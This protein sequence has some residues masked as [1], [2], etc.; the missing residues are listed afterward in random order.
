MVVPPY[1]YILL[2]LSI[3]VTDSTDQ[4]RSK[5]NG[6]AYHR[7]RIARNLARHRIHKILDSQPDM[8]ENDPE[9]LGRDFILTQVVEVS[10]HFTTLEE[11][12]RRG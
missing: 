7:R 10:S 3:I 8:S 6:S 11:V 1:F 9:A 12:K 4:R 2:W 5:Y